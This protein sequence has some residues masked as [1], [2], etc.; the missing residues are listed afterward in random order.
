MEL[1]FT[2]LIVLAPLLGITGI[3]LFI[4]RKTQGKERLSNV[5]RGRYFF[6]SGFVVLLLGIVGV[7]VVADP[8][9]EMANAIQSGR[10]ASANEQ[11]SDL[12]ENGDNNGQS[13]ELLSESEFY[14]MLASPKD[15]IGSEV[16]FIAKVFS[17]EKDNEG[18]YLQVWQDIHNN[19]NNMIVGIYDPSFSVST[20][21]YIKVTA[22]IIDEFTGE[23]AFGATLTLPAVEAYDYELIGYAD[24]V[25]PTEHEVDV[26]ETQE[27]SG[28]VVTIDKIEFG[29]EDFRLFVEIENQSDNAINF[30]KHSAKIVAGNNQYDLDS[31]WAADY[32]EIQSEIL[33]GVNSNGILSFPYI[34]YEKI[35]QVTVHLSGSSDDW[36]ISIDDFVFNIE[37]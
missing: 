22:E 25:S 18:V 8:D 7:V 27:Q 10:E 17:V 14:Q 1:L 21:N 6:I 20:D 4:I 5:W 32:P 13:S 37:W 36:D 3:I 31:N 30:W 12:E 19:E 26:S 16:E 34:D 2:L 33:P 15:Y 29:T 23:N 28:F 24:A 35:K 11:P 9:D